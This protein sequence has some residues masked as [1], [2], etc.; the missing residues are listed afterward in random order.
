MPLMTR[1]LL[2]A[3]IL[4]LS[5]AT[6]AHAGCA[7][8]MTGVGRAANPSHYDPPRKYDVVE[9]ARTRA[10]LAWLKAV[11]AECPGRSVIWLRS[12]GRKVECEGYAGGTECTVTAIPALS[13]WKR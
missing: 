8:G 9:L 13:R 3:S 7:D 10:E 11:K 12:S 4:A 5:P 6:L 2:A 1:G